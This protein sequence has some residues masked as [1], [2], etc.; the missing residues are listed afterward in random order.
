[1]AKAD[2]NAINAILQSAKMAHQA[3]NL[4]EAEAGYRRILAMNPRHPEALH[5]LGVIAIGV[6]MYTDA[7]DLFER[8]VALDPKNLNYQLDLAR[9]HRDMGHHHEAVK[10]FE[11]ARK[12]A[13][14]EAIVLAQLADVLKLTGEYEKAI[15]LA[16]QAL[17]MYPRVAQLFATKVTAL[18]RLDRHKEA[19]AVCRE[20][21]KLADDAEVEPPL[22]ISVIFGQVAQHLGLEDEAVERLQKGL[23]QENARPE[24][25]M[26][27]YFALGAI[28]DARSN[29]EAA[30][31]YYR[32]ANTA[33]PN[34][35]NADNH[36][37]S[38]DSLISA[39]S[40]ERVASMRRSRSVTEAPVFIVGVP[41]SGTSLVEQILAAH[42]G[43]VAFGE[44]LDIW[45]AARR[46]S[47]DTR[48]PYMTPQFMDAVSVNMLD[49]AAK[50]YTARFRS[51]ARGATRVTDKLPTN[52]LN[53]GLIAQMLPGARIIH[54]SRDPM[55]TC[56]SNYAVH[57][58]NDLPFARNLT[59]LGR[60]CR[61]EQR[62]MNHFKQ[63]LDLPILDVQ[64]EQLVEDIEGQ[65]RRMLD[66]LDLDWDDQ[67]LRYYEQDRRIVTAS[68]DQAN[69][70]VYTSSIGRHKP[71][72]PMLDELKSALEHGKV[73]T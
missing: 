66:F 8:A 52:F 49:D 24:E 56:W 6:S 4:Q 21:I 54:C 51:S 2:P 33:L 61:D 68:A 28:E 1:M 11:R 15:D 34:R 72:L 65:S 45:D 46:L 58:T 29:H 48:T 17:V 57:F 37:R 55:D 23:K 30:F 59:D 22:L 43:V 31:E 73:S 3:G 10:V 47:R 12:I 69:K 60:Y 13:P 32:L 25:R 38:I 16:D 42:P 53:V 63:V 27:A 67:V 70:P 41:R 40:P 35:W 36:S 39:Y 71:Y 64:Y 5:D 18:A 44:L 14:N 7:I 50:R 9:A 20:A 62:L 19:E 26:S